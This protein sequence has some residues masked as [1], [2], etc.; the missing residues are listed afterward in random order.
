MRKRGL[1]L[2][3]AVLALS[4][5][6]ALTGFSTN[7][8]ERQMFRA[9]LTGFEEVNT[10]STIVT[11][12]A[13]VSTLSTTGNGRLRLRID[14]R[15]RE[16]EFELTYFDLEG[17]TTTAAHI[18]LGARG[19]AGGVVAFLC[20]GGGRP[21]CTNPSGSFSGT[22]TAANIVGGAVAQGI[23]PG[24]FDE[25]VRAIRAGFTYVNVHTNRFLGGEIRGQIR[26]DNVNEP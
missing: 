9:R 10:L 20:G 8:D 7:A 18:H 19:V 15:A 5:L 26:T 25:V 11:P 1:W 22:I 24:E 16:I 4:A 13:V 17:T 6:L 21:A 23:A 14:D 2:S 3:L 12:P